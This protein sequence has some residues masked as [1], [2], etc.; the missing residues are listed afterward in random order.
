M[1]FFDIDQ[2]ICTK[3]FSVPQSAINAIHQLKENGHHVALSSGRIKYAM[4]RYIDL[5]DIEHYVCSEGNSAYYKHQLI[6]STPIPTAFI[7]QVLERAKEL[8]LIVGMVSDSYNG[9]TQI[10]EVV[11]AVPKELSLGKY[12]LDPT[13][14]LDQPIY[15]VCVY[16]AYENRDLFP[17][18]KE[19]YYHEFKG[20][21]VFVNIGKE[22]GIE[23]MI[24][25]LGLST[26]DVVVFGDEFNDLS[27]FDFAATSVAMGN[28]IDLLKEKATFV[29]R[30]VE[31]DG[32]EYACKKLGLI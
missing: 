29:T 3:D 16:G 28:A 26:E 13:H 25:H 24:H 8:N 6:L 15:K 12:R 20:H 22:R 10:N 2:T 11:E 30:S 31:E 17:Q 14:Y 23:A 19:H 18:S 21:L 27:M 4:E 5:L 32:I 1:I 9:V 7:E